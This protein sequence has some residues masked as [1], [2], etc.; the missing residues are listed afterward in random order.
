MERI[1]N[2]E[3]LKS[4]CTRIAHVIEGLN[5]FDKKLV[6]EHMSTLVRLFDDHHGQD[7]L[8]KTLEKS[9]NDRKN[10]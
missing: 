3:L 8:R 4:Y 10:D 1:I 6:I 2:I 9:K 5:L 7:A